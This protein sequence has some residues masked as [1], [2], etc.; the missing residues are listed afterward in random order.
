VPPRGQ[1]SSDVALL[2][3]PSGLGIDFPYLCVVKHPNIA[4]G[5]K[6][7]ALGF[8]LGFD[9]SVRPGAITSLLND[10]GLVQSNMGLARGMSGGPVLD[11]R[12]A[13]IGIVHGGIEGQSSFD[14]FTPANLALPVFDTPPASYVGDS[15][16]SSQQASVRPA[17]IERSYQIDETYDEHPGL[18]PTSKEYRITKAAD[19]NHIIVD[20]RVVRQS[21]SRV[22]DLV[23]SISPDRRSVELKFRLTAGPI[24]DRWRGWLHGQLI[25]AMEPAD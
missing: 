4:N 14:Y 12:R 16:Q 5:G 21:D 17:T 10:K 8:P 13:V 3:F 15:C 7:T 9:L 19:P 24:F 20:T 11:E 23:T 2:K 25:L 22:S 18:A 1:V 6:I